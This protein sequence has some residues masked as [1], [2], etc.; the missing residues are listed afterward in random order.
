MWKL[1][2]FGLLAYIIGPGIHPGTFFAPTSGRLYCP[3]STPYMMIIIT[4]VYFDFLKTQLG[5]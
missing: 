1:G 4:N 5:Y 3:D 2:T